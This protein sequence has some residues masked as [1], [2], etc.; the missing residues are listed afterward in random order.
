[1]SNTGDSSNDITVTQPVH[2]LYLRMLIK[3]LEKDDTNESHIP[4]TL[5][6][7][8]GVIYGSVISRNAW[9]SLWVEE[10]KT[11][12]GVGVDLV[13]D[14]PNLIDSA[15]DEAFKEEG[16]ERPADDG[17]R[18]IHL[19]QA[20]MLAPGVNRIGVPLWRGRLESVVGWNVGTVGL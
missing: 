20:T 14:F 12:T 6:T 11:A 3:M 9:K 1:M 10:M 19:K 15:I 7:N 8:S 17:P 16:I 18:F 5:A 13:R 2:D 4:I